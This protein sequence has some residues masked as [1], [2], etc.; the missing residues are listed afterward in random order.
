MAVCSVSGPLVKTSHSLRGPQMMKSFLETVEAIGAPCCWVEAPTS[1]A[2]S[3]GAHYPS[4][5]PLAQCMKKD[6]PH[7]P[8]VSLALESP[9]SR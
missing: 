4:P 1:K 8:P 5:P 6:S 7:C 9:M 2:P 3:L